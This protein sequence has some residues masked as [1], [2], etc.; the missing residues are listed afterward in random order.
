MPLPV[1]DLRN[2]VQA[3]GILRCVTL[4]TK[5][6]AT[7]LSSPAGK[8]SIRL[9]KSDG[10]AGVTVEDWMQANGLEPPGGRKRDGKAA[11]ITLDA[12]RRR[13][14]A[15][16]KMGG[17]AGGG[18]AG[19][20]FGAAAGAAGGGGT[21]PQHRAGCL[22]VICKQARAYQ[23]AVCLAHHAPSLLVTSTNITALFVFSAQACV[24]SRFACMR[25]RAARLS[26]VLAM[27]NAS[28]RAAGLRVPGALG[29][30]GTWRSGA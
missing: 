12:V 27:P 18:A 26:K 29:W 15:L 8:S 23:L 16:M 5:A 21:W 25:I 28:K 30:A 14:A 10:R 20:G 6:T 19:G 3:I 7:A 24:S 22:C 11:N 17:A 4:C 9:M 1:I 13:A 2:W